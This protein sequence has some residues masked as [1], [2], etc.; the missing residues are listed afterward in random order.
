MLINAINNI[1]NYRH[2]KIG[3]KDRFCASVLE[4]VLATITFI[5]IKILLECA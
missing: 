3:G 4:E 5:E 2:Q 1:P